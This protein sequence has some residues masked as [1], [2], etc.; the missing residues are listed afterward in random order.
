M[1]AGLEACPN[2]DEAGIRIFAKM[3]PE[4][5]Q[6]TV[7]RFFAMPKTVGVTARKLHKIPELLLDLAAA[8]ANEPFM[9]RP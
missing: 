4:Q 9:I 8:S 5:V 3:Q 6:Q 7:R 1:P 2:D